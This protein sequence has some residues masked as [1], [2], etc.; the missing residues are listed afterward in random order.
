MIVAGHRDG[1]RL[2]FDE[3]GYQELQHAGARVGMKFRLSSGRYQLRMVLCDLADGKI[4]TR[5]EPL[6]VIPLSEDLPYISSLVLHTATVTAIDRADTD[7]D[8][9]PLRLGKE[10]IVPSLARSYPREGFLGVYFHVYNVSE[11]ESQPYQYR[12]NLYRDEVLA[13]KSDPHAVQ[14]KNRHPLKGYVFSWRLSLS[15]L[16]AGEYR[17]EAEVSLPDGS[18]RVSRSASFRID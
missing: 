11:Q 9:N 15:D 13:T 7:D 3:A 17:V 12:L 16:A 2:T 10:T 1:Y 6:E 4:S 5:N 18:N 14:S 8:Y